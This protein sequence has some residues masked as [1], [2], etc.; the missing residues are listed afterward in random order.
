MHYF[1]TFVT[2]CQHFFTNSFEIIQNIISS[3]VFLAFQ[4]ISHHLFTNAPD[5]QP[6]PLVGSRWV[7]ELFGV[8]LSGD[9][10]N[11]GLQ[12]E[13]SHHPRNVFNCF[14]GNSFN[15]ASTGRVLQ[16]DCKTEPP[17]KKM[18]LAE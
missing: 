13:M 10:V 18:A 3:G 6:L 2:I 8:P 7:E 1:V 4:R 17:L 5:Q 9:P 15:P 16:F 14:L 12:A 11:A